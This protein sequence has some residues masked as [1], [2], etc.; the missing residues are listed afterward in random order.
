MVCELIQRLVKLQDMARKRHRHIILM[1]IRMP[2]MDGIIR[3]HAKSANLMWKHPLWPCLPMFFDE[4]TGQQ[5][6]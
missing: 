2:V 5:E 6:Q 1:D 4:M 3:P